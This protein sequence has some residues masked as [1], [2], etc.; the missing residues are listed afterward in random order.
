MW[1]SLHSYDFLGVVRCHG[2]R[3]LGRGGDWCGCVGGWVSVGRAGWGG[4][5]AVIDRV[6]GK[7]R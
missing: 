4:F 2:R 6:L 7:R 5:V 3:R 1:V